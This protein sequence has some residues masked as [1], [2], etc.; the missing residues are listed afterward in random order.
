MRELYFTHYHGRGPVSKEVQKIFDDGH[1]I[2]EREQSKYKKI[3]GDVLECEKEIHIKTLSEL[4]IIG[5]ADCF[6][7][8]IPFVIEIKSCSKLP[9]KPQ[10]QHVQQIMLYMHA[11]GADYGALNYIQ[12]SDN[13]TVSFSIK[14]DKYTA[15]E[16]IGFFEKL[17]F[18]INQKEIP[19]CS[20]IYGQSF[21]CKQFMKGLVS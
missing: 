21:Y 16:T 12:K 4:D 19:D 2:H 8:S 1:K 18:R 3:Y 5:H 13:D 15:F 9:T 7:T 11:L 17:Y 6:L 20:C 10:K 14:Y